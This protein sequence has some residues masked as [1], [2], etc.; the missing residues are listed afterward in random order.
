MNPI[1]FRQRSDI[2]FGFQGGAYPDGRVSLTIRLRPDELLRIEQDFRD[3]RCASGAKQLGHDTAGFMCAP[4]IDR[5]VVMS[6]NSIAKQGDGVVPRRQ[7][8]GHD[9]GADYGGEKGTSPP[10]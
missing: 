7:M 2:G 9:A 8:L 5:N 1:E 6:T 3:E 10:P 4:H